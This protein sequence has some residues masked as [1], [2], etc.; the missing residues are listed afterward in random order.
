MVVYA[1]CIFHEPVAGIAV[2]EINRSIRVGRITGR[3]LFCGNYVLKEKEREKE[4]KSAIGRKKAPDQLPDK[5]FMH[6][7]QEHKEKLS[8]E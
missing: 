6:R 5:Q 3:Q 4:R 2:A 7:M 1:K 8:H